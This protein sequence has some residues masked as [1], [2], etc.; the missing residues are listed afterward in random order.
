MHRMQE[1]IE[2][3]VRGELSCEE[4]DELWAIFLSDPDWYEYFST[5]LHLVAIEIELVKK[6]S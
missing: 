2:K 4:V 5:W 3:Y 1:K 6:E